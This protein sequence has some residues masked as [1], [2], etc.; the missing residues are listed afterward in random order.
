MT[1]PQPQLPPGPW[2]K[3]GSNVLDANGHVVA[4]P[5]SEA[6]ADLMLRAER[7]D[8]R[9]GGCT[10]GIMGTDCYGEAIDCHYCGGSGWVSSQ[11]F[12]DVCDRLHECLGD[13]QIAHHELK[14]GA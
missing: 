3:I 1:T 14:E 7:G 4:M 6:V 9:C 12:I 5:I 8:I 10:D 2:T 11:A 13:L